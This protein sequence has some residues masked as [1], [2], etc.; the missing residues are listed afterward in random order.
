MPAHRAVVGTMSGDL[1][2][3]VSGG[4]WVH[5]VSERVVRR[6]DEDDLQRD[7][8]RFLDVALPTGATYFAVPNGGKRHVREAARMKGLGLRPGVPDLLVIHNGRA[9][10]VE[11]K[12]KRGVMSAAQ[13]AMQKM[14]VYCGCDVMLCRSVPEVE[15]GL[16][17]CGVHLKASVSA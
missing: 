17:E 8:C 4:A 5:R 15:A 14:L 12:T 6:H 9:L 10:F 7:V 2:F 11:L 16:R 1:P 13:K 3:G